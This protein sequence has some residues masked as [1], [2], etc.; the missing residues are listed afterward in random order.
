MSMSLMLKHDLKPTPKKHLKLPSRV[1]FKPSGHM[2]VRSRRSSQHFG[3]LAWRVS[4]T[5][6]PRSS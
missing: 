5:W 1:L 2:C 6:A 4:P 3:L